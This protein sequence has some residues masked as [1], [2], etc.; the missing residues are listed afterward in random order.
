MIRLTLTVTQYCPE[1][2]KHAAALNP[3]SM[4]WHSI[5]GRWECHACGN[6]MYPA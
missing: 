2:S 4:V 3:W 6:V 5:Q 1:G